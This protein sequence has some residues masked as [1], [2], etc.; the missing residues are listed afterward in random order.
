[1]TLLSSWP[2]AILHCDADS[3]YVGCEL[4]RRPELKGKPV[5]VTGKLGDIV[6]AK[7]YDLKAQGVKTGMPVWEM[8]KKLPNIIFLPADFEFY[9]DVSAQMFGILRK[10]TPGVEVYSVDEAFLD[11]KGFRRLYKMDYTQMAYAIKEDVK[12]TLG[13]TV[14]MGISVNRTL[15]KM[16]AKFN[17]PDGVTTI[18]WKHIKDWLPRFPIEAVP[19]FGRNTVPLLEKFGI[20][21]CA[22]FVNLTETTVKNLLHRPGLDLWKELQGEKVFKIE[23]T[24]AP[25]K[26]IT[27]TSSFDPHT[28]DQKFLWAHTVRQLERALDALHDDHQMTQEVALYLRDK[29]FRRYGWSYRFPTPVKS[30]ALVLEALKTLWREHFPRGRVFRS[31]GVT[32]MRLTQDTGEQFSLF[33]D[34]GFIVRKDQLEQAKQQLKDRYGSLSIRSAS[35]LSLKMLGPNRRKK[36]KAKAFN[37]EW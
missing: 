16:A 22:D 7:T 37:V 33:E 8:K 25:N 23:A 5:V 3:F 29:A 17:K 18:S 36:L 20:H 34:P 1:M 27:R 6:L 12:K 31:T 35:S 13:I 4:S 26:I 32:L 14:S 11:I 9:N 24:F 10:W 15:S 2:E 19:G 30:F 28:A 21:T